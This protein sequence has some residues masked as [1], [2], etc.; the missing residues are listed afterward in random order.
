MRIAD[1]LKEI[2]VDE[3]Y[4]PRQIKSALA[5]ICNISYQ[6][7]QA[8][9]LNSDPTPENIAKISQHFGVNAIWII[10]GSGE[11]HITKLD[12][13]ERYIIEGWRRLPLAEREILVR[14][15]RAFIDSHKTSTTARNQQA[16]RI[17]EKSKSTS[18]CR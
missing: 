5:K 6:A 13:D 17:A 4:S 7:V 14:Q 3:G 15:Q 1:R 16:M 18:A 9:F 2:C 8:W 10:T 11:R 12:N